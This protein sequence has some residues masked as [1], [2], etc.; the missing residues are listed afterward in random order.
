M[1]R[2]GYEL[3]YD[4]AERSLTLWDLATDTAIYEFGPAEMQN[5]T[6]PDGVRLVADGRGA[7]I[8]FEDPETG[9]DL[10]SFT[11]DDMAFLVGMA[12][13]Q[14]D[15]A[16]SGVPAEPEPWV[17]WSAGGSAWGWQSLADAFGIHDASIWPEFAVGHDF[18]I[19]RV[20]AFQPPDPADA[21]D[22]GHFLPKRWF[23]ARAP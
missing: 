16:S 6:P 4:E 7:G 19:T 22:D 11:T 15:D 21:G 1:A 8:V 20:A 3:R 17:G 14:V 2:D 9:A 18:V 12:S 13:A 5:D 10:V 23:L